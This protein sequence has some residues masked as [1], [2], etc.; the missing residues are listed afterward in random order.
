MLHTYHAEI[1]DAVVDEAKR[2]VALYLHAK[3]TADAG[4]Y[5][6]EYIITLTMTEDGTKVQDQYDFIDS[7]RMIEWIGKMGQYAKDTWENK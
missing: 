5:E 4:E 6:N 2:K 3:A 1:T 7:H